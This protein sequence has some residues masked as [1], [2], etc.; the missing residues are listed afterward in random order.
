MVPHK[1]RL[2][3]APFVLVL[4]AAYPVIR[5][6]QTRGAMSYPLDD[7]YIHLVLAH[8]LA[9]AGHYGTSLA[10]AANSSS[11]FLWPW[12]LAAIV[13]LGCKSIYLPLA[14]AVA[15]ATGAAFAAARLLNATD[16]SLRATVAALVM[17]CSALPLMAFAGMEH[18]LHAALVLLLATEFVAVR[19]RTSRLF[20]WAFLGTLVRFE[21]LAPALLFA[22]VA[23]ICRLRTKHGNAPYESALQ[24]YAPALGTAMALGTSALVM[25][26]I[27]GSA[28]PLPV[29]LKGVHVQNMHD[30]H[31]WFDT[32]AARLAEPHIWVPLALGVL[33]TLQQPRAN[34]GANDPEE[35]QA[36]VRARQLVV[37]AVGTLL[38][39][40]AFGGVGWFHRYEAYALLLLWSTIARC[41]MRRLPRTRER[42]ESPTLVFVFAASVLIFATRGLV[43]VGGAHVAAENIDDQQGTLLRLTNHLQASCGLQRIAANDVGQL[44]RATGVEVLDLM[45]ITSREVAALRNYRID[46][47]LSAATVE[48]LTSIHATEL[49]FVYPGWASREPPATW[50]R[51]ASF[52]IPNN[53]VCANDTVVLYRVLASKRASESETLDSRASTGTQEAEMKSAC[54]VRQTS[55]FLTATSSTSKIKVAFGGIAPGN[56]R[57]P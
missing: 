5:I 15:C 12:L 19:P 37:V 2:A 21:T 50:K 52:A 16:S 56:P 36:R 27:T 6:H 31:V 13:R 33:T 38:L 32:M 28:L 8:N 17:I 55:Q 23:L 25:R 53:R 10:D 47:P 41:I 51:L 49:A 26:A 22:S 42:S 45:G 34:V 57:S 40:I 54:L 11:S 30:A 18:A 4:L 1:G 24:A 46:E 14:L 48:N 29:R 39:Q 20:L 9:A 43:L 44:G 3:L 7:T 35:R